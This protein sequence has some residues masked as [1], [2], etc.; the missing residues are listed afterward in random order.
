MSYENG[1][2]IDITRKAGADLSGSQYLFVKEDANGNIIVCSAAGEDALGVLQNKPKA[3]A[4]AVVRVEG[5]SKVVCSAALATNISIAT[6]A[7]GKAKLAA[8]L[9]QA[10]GAGSFAMGRLLDAASG[11]G[12]IQSALIRAMGVLPTAAA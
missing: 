9:V 1:P 6:D 11:A 10:T 4:P 8:P 3:G 5:V 12:S 2:V 7:T